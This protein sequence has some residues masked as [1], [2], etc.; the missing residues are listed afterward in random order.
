MT[1]L[2]FL[3]AQGSS[4]L[5]GNSSTSSR[6]STYRDPECDVR[7]VKPNVSKQHARLR[8]DEN[9]QVLFI[10][11]RKLMAKVWLQNISETNVTLLNEKVFSDEVMLKHNDVFTICDRSFRL[12]CPSIK[13]SKAIEVVQTPPKKVLE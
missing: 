12:E 5:E 3:F 1:A 9:F 7:I 2:P 13:P 11:M 4:N 8:L 10:G 6:S